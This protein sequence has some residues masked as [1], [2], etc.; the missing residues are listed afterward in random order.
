MR[1]EINAI[2]E[3]NY[4]YS[5]DYFKS[6]SPEEMK[7]IVAELFAEACEV[8]GINPKLVFGDTGKPN[9]G[10]VYKHKNL[11]DWRGTV[12][13]N[14]NKFDRDGDYT[15]LGEMLHELYH[16]YQH[17]V[18]DGKVEHGENSSTVAVWKYNFNNY[19][20]SPPWDAYY[21]QAVEVSA[22]WFGGVLNPAYYNETYAGYYFSRSDLFLG[23]W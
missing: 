18:V 9:R 8:M 14:P 13:I 3:G 7:K 21:N 20:E 19:K 4:R 22:N 5:R 23:N 10:G 17:A 1:D 15:V 11:F 12:T 16:C 2:I 6:V